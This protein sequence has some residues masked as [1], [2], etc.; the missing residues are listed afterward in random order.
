MLASI[1]TMLVNIEGILKRMSDSVTIVLYCPPSLNLILSN[2]S[3]NFVKNH[4]ES[5]VKSAMY[6]TYLIKCDFRAE[7]SSKLGDSLFYHYKF[8]YLMA[9]MQLFHSSNCK[10]CES[11]E[12]ADFAFLLFTK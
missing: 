7:L 3:A 11:V 9:K 8:W 4:L 5:K 2:S 10:H 6:N 12:F 1:F